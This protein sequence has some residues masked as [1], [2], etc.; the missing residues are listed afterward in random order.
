MEAGD[1]PELGREAADLTSRSR[2]SREELLHDAE[3]RREAAEL[4][5]RSRWWQEELLREELLSR[6]WYGPQSDEHV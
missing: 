5:S 2:P 4:L 1:T 3:L 6:E